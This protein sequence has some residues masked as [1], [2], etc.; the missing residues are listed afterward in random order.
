MSILEQ[1]S[2]KNV[3]GFFEAISQIPRGSFRHEAICDFL[4]GFAKERGLKCRRDSYGNVVIVKEAFAGYEESD[5]V[6]LQGHTDMVCEKEEGC[7]IDF[8][9]DG[10]ALYTDGDFLKAR[11]TT[12]GADDGFAVACMLAV[13]DDKTLRHPYIEAVFTADEEVG[14]LGAKALDAAELKGR[15]LLNI[16]SD[17]EGH[18]LTSCAGGRTVTAKFPAHA[19]DRTGLCISIRLHGL[20]GGHSGSEIDKDR[21]NAAIETGRILHELSV[22]ADA[23]IVSL[24]GGKKD[25]V[26]PREAK[27]KIVV[28]SEKKEK[29]LAVLSELEKTLS[30][31]YAA[32]DPGLK[33]DA[34]VLG[35]GR[36]AA[37]SGESLR[38]ALSYLRC[39]PNGA[40]RRSADG[41]GIVETSLNAGILK[42]ED[43]QVLVTSSVRSSV[44]S[45]KEELVKR[46]SVLAG[47]C[48]GTVAEDGDYPAWEYRADSPVRE[49]IAETYREMFGKEPVFEAI[50]A[51]LECGIL[52]GKLPGLD[53]V[54]FGPDLFDIHTPAERLSISSAE[55]V[56]KFL[57][58]LLGSMK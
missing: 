14:L 49:R 47:L 46:L 3:F 2:L 44:E 10:L 4:E 32:S 20:C 12:L 58:R 52:S 9:K 22:R 37:L 36:Y 50:H 13:L 51:G 39:L 53:A 34:A 21:A 11:G 40:Q 16:D 28:S 29:A 17:R 30:K 5:A 27:A 18:F 15:V 6:I 7:A 48:G 54:S 41:S 26:I 35:E 57:I 19:A 24:E 23:A 25:N 55:R 56:Y 45:R 33:L 42:W 38:G 31:E 8:E 43:G 1:V